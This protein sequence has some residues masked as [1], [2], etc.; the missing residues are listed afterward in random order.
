M[1]SDLKNFN[2]ITAYNNIS[3]EYH[4]MQLELRSADNALQSV[5]DLA[6]PFRLCLKNLEYLIAILLFI[7]EPR[8]ILMLG[9]AAGSLLHFLRHHY[10]QAEITT[11]DIDAELIETLKSR[12]ILPAADANLTYVIDDARHYIQHC[13]NSFDLILVDIFDGSQSPGWLL[14][15]TFIDRLHQQLARDGAVAYNLLIE[16]DHL[17][18]RFYRDLRLVFARQTLSMPVNGFENTIVYGFSNQ[19]PARE[20]TWYMQRSLEMSR[21]QAIDYIRILS[22]IYTSNPSDGGVL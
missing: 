17:F 12:A 11:V 7:P 5:I 13:Q 14:E 2:I 3:A 9:T 19:L 10:P 6:N 16:S 4:G 18:T 22:V 15:K 20:M 21:L 8:R 1:D